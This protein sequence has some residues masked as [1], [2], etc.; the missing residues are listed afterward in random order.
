M[1]CMRSAT[2][3]ASLTLIASAAAANGFTPISDREEFLDLIEGRELRLG[4]LGISLQIM[5]DGLIEGRAAG[6]DV[7]GTWT[8]EDG[9]FCREMDW[10]GTEIPYN[11]QLVEIE[12]G[13]RI[14]FTVDRG[15]GDSATLNIR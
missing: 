10:S 13:D 3:V 11:C 6:W 15:E 2:L 4:A 7:D 14:R 8:W 12:G 5:P 9:F 1:F